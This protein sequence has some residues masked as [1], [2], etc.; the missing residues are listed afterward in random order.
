MTWEEELVAFLLLLCGL[1]MLAGA[2]GLLAV[3]VYASSVRMRAWWRFLKATI[4]AAPYN[5]RHAAARGRERRLARW[6]QRAAHQRGGGGA[7]A[8]VRRG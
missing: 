8:R 3:A 7:N 5:G 4:T 2:G 1:G 6:W